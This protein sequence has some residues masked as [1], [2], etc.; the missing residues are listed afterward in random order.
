VRKVDLRSP[1][2]F[3][4]DHVRGA[5]N[6]P[7]FDDDQRAVVGTLYK[8]ESPDAA[9]EH[10]LEMVQKK[11]G[12]LLAS[13]LG[14]PIAADDLRQRFDEL[15]TRLKAGVSAVTL[16]PL[17]DVGGATLAVYCW[18]GGMRSRSVAALL[19]ALGIENVVLVQGGYKDYR[20]WVRNSL[21]LI[22]YAHS[23][24]ILRGPTG[25]GKT[26]ILH[27]L[28]KELPGSTIDLEGLAQHRSSV[29]GAVGLEPVSKPEFDSRL[30]ERL[31]ELGPRPWFVEG[32]SRKVGDVEIPPT[33]FLGME[34]GAHVRLEASMGYRTALL[35]R[36]YL[37]TSHHV[38][39]LADQLQFLE[40]R[41]GAKWVGRLREWLAAGRWQEVAEV[42]LER[43]YDPRYGHHDERRT[44]LARFDASSSSLIADLS[45]L[46]SKMMASADLK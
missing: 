29:L 38:E 27:Q 36:E 24:I 25:V 5:W 12:D 33:F 40:K 17:A 31:S 2:E 35:A 37:A 4:R 20:Q 7:L 45:A 43:W 26:Q 30:L 13:I 9:F 34:D 14:Y 19:L 39:Q 15:A 44:W 28:E 3:A 32:E 16:E 18:R 10:G 21:E 8:Q 22:S 41:L 1:S 46:R 6:V 42:L 23:F 11:L